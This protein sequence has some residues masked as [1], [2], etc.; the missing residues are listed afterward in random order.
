MSDEE[1][2]QSTQSQDQTPPDPDFDGEPP[3]TVMILDAA[4]AKPDSNSEE[5]NESED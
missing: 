3:G 4:P 2:N 1:N 5:I